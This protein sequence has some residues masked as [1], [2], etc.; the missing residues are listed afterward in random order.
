MNNKK[1][2]EKVLIIKPFGPAIGKATIPENIINTLNEY[3]DKIAEDEIKSNLL[4]YGYKLA[5]NVKQ[6]FKLE[7]E[8]LEESGWLNFLANNSKEWINLS[9]KKKIT[10]F[11]LITSWIVRQ[12]NNEYNPIHWHNGHISGVGY[13][14]VPSNFGKTFQK[15]KSY[16]KNGHLE[17]IY[18]S[19]SFLNNPVF[20]IIPKVGDFY[21]FP[22]YLM[23]TVYPFFDSNE[24]RRSISF[25]ARIDIG[26]YES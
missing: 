18:G 23:H 3:V 21:F 17:L 22:N 14:K 24:E 1:E 9:T 10:K 6:E 11:E 7:N 13:L 15:N 4:D 20:N 25:N 26:L 12:F 16:N 19:K 5:G 8:M 2:E